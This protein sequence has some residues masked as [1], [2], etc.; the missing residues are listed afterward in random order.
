MTLEREGQ[1]GE[2]E[3]LLVLFIYTVISRTK[4]KCMY[5]CIG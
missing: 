5:T 4:G 3:Q 1:V 2:R